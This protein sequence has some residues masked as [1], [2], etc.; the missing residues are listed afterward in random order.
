MN[1]KRLIIVLVLIIFASMIGCHADNS[2]GTFYNQEVF[3]YGDGKLSNGTLTYIDFPQYWHY[4]GDYPY[5]FG[6]IKGGKT[7]Y[8]ADENGTIVKEKKPFLADMDYT[9]WIREDMV[10]PDLCG[11]KIAVMVNF[12]D[13]TSFSLEGKAKEEFIEWFRKYKTNEK[14]G[15]YSTSNKPIGN[16]VF[17][18]LEIPGLYYYCDFLIIQ[19]SNSIV[20]VDNFDKKIA[21]F[22]Q[23]TEFYH[24]VC[25]CQGQ[26]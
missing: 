18:S 5:R 26:D 3:V 12:M 19:L 17:E 11:D 24:D 4:K 1:T 25:L 6:K 21:S 13:N 10:L 22:G 14:K 15:F 7:L 23:N 8:A 16:I 20:I 9:P 2:A